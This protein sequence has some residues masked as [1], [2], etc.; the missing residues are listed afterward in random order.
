[1]RATLSGDYFFLLQLKHV[2]HIRLTWSC[3][4]E[5]ILWSGCSSIFSSP[6][7]GQGAFLLYCSQRGN[8]FINGKNFNFFGPLYCHW[9][10]HWVRDSSIK[11]LILKILAYNRVP[12]WSLSTC[13]HCVGWL[14]AS[15]EFPFVLFFRT[16][17]NQ[18]TDITSSEGFVLKKRDTDLKLTDHHSLCVVGIKLHP[19]R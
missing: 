17:L 2:A 9:S 16:K 5:W 19:V 14:W 13:A 18:V 4:V 1:M 6:G 11:V 7:L 15:P 8:I 10:L 12:I 3:I